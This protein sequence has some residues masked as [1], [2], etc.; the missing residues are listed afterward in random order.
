VVTDA[1]PEDCEA[2]IAVGPF[3]EVQPATTRAIQRH[4][5]RTHQTP[6]VFIDPFLRE[7][8]YKTCVLIVI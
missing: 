1:D 3:D 7:R 5:T 8:G 6:G 2:V 4:T